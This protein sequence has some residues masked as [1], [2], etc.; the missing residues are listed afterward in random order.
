MLWNLG[1]ATPCHKALDFVAP[2]CPPQ[3]PARA[4]LQPTGVQPSP[5]IWAAVALPLP[6]SWPYQAGKASLKFSASCVFLSLEI[7][8][9]LYRRKAVST[10][11][12]SQ[13]Q[14]EPWT[15]V[16]ALPKACALSPAWKGLLQV[17]QGQL[18]QTFREWPL[19]CRMGL[20][21]GSCS[22]SVKLHFF[23]TPILSLHLLWCIHPFML[24][25]KLQDRSLGKAMTGAPLV[26]T[27]NAACAAHT[28]HHLLLQVYQ[29]QNFTCY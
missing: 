22:T 17:A 12:L 25:N 3:L 24:P 14:S 18:F 9:K 13:S 5:G 8:S 4:A 19:L 16:T 2:Q 11:L 23:F 20:P 6:K 28:S 27:A 10:S 1:R 29:S 26:L 21:A 7:P 15:L